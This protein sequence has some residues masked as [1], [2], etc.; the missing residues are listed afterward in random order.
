MAGA[1]AES[2]AKKARLE[3]LNLLAHAKPAALDALRGVVSFLGLGAGER[4][5]TRVHEAERYYFVA[6]GQ[7]G[8]V[9]DRT[10]DVAPGAPSER[11]LKE[12]RKRW[13]FI[14]AFGIGDF[15][16]DDYVRRRAS[17]GAPSLDCVAEELSVVAAIP[18]EALDAAMRHDPRLKETL[19]QRNAELRE[20]YHQ[21]RSSARRLIQDFY[22]R[23]GLGFAGATKVLQ[24]DRCIDCNACEDACAARHGAS[25]LTHLGPS[26]G[27][28]SFPIA[29]RTCVD[30]RCLE[31]CA[32]EAITLKDDGAL[33]T[34]RQKCVGCAA[35]QT[36]CPNGVIQMLEVPYVGTDFPNPMPD[37]TAAGET[38]VPGV[39]LIGEAAGDGLIKLAINSGVRAVEA[40]AA[41][42]R[43]PAPTGGADVII[44][45]AGPAGL[46]AALACRQRG[47]SF[48]IFDK[49]SLATTIQD[50]PRHKIVMAE[51]AHI[52]LY[53]ELWLKDTTREA[54]LAKWQ[55]IVKTTGLA[56]HSEEAVLA[57]NADRDGS[58]TVKTAKDE[59]HARAV[60]VAVGTRGTPR[61]LGV[62][63][64]T[65]ARVK[66]LLTDPS[67]YQGQ[68]LLVVGGGDSA[69]EAAMT[70][71]DEPGTKVA[72]SY[73]KDSFG[74]IKA[75]NKARLE[76]YTK[77]G[78]LSVFLSSTVKRIDEDDVVLKLE[79]GEERFT[80]QTIFA[81]LG[82]EPPT[83]F[84]ESIGIR[85]IK[86]ATPEMDTLA[87]GRGLRQ[88]ASRCDRCQGFADAACV[89]ACPTG[90]ILEVKPQELFF[91]GAAANGPGIANELPFLLG[92]ERP[93]KGV[94][95]WLTPLVIL[96]AA[97]A[98]AT[99]GLEVFL[100]RAAPE[101]SF[102]HRWLAARGVDP[103]VVFE[104]GR[105][106]GLYLGIAGSMLMLLA[107]AYPLH[108]RLGWL[109]PL[110]G[111]R[112]FM[113]LHVWAGL[114]GP[115]LITYHTG[116]KLD[117]WPSIAFWGAWVV[118]LSGVMGRY[119]KSWLRRGAGLADLEMQS[120]MQAKARLMQKWSGIRGRTR[121]FRTFE[122]KSWVERTPA[123]LAPFVY[124]GHWLVTLL[125]ASWL[126]HVGLRQVLTPSLKNQTLESYI[127]HSLAIRRRMLAQV[128]TGSVIWWRRFHLVVSIGMFGVA[129]THVVL[130]LLYK[131]H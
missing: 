131:A 51:P 25:R 14:S 35:C 54:L 56:I 37:T 33:L 99:V 2:L 13:Q 69:V 105:G 55:E 124:V 11:E 60:I 62:D 112:W 111:K 71:A 63:G 88:L 108:S 86:P 38:N 116:L 50:Y 42:S 80:N 47:L 126:R 102:W 82:A 28:L 130:G 12:L 26:L 93:A 65:A 59:Y 91:V 9:I 122:S 110:A 52:P 7:I 22:L 45:G 32:F 98:T 129:I 66:Y 53:G 120:L 40:I 113:T 73:R 3:D 15:F 16:S 72:L 92:I 24:L 34:N 36:A 67:E 39:Y 115:V 81:M 117:R 6:K 74:R 30:H 97:L 23:H 125:R 106:M 96:A 8:V 31:A 29:C 119:I 17:P 87:A 5:S 85:I 95:R 79:V 4:L 128:A 19:S 43:E 118:V 46:S 57:V 49:G 104:S 114:F 18:T 103:T 107:A 90:A 10:G 123:L 100:R 84:F 121:I 83:K 21:N 27:V 127:E 68:C 101:L 64:E 89:A 20:L 77:S 78:K 76:E 61:R 109:A 48:E 44:V 41:A 70:L 58:L 94:A 75:R 1:S